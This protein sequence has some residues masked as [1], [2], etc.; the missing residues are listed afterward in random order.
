MR[1]VLVATMLTCALPA[2][3]AQTQ[4][5]AET[6]GDPKPDTL[7]AENFL[8]RQRYEDAIRQS[9]LALGRDERYVPAMVV[10]AKAYY[11]ERK[12]EL[13]TS[14]IDIAK[15]IDPNNAECYNL[16]GFIALTR[17]DRISATAAFRKAT[18]LDPRYGNAWDNL[19]AQ[20]LYGKNYDGAL[21]AA[22]KATQLLPVFSKAW[23]NLG[24]AY[25][26]KQEYPQAETA[27]KRATQLDPNYADAYFNLGILYL[28]A[29]QMPGTDLITKL[30]TS[31][32]YLNK[33]KQLA[34][35]RLKPDDPAD[36]YI[37]EARTGIEREQKRIQRMQRQQQRGEPKT[38]PAPAG[39][40]AG[41]K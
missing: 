7:A 34:S 33:Y 4:L 15:S 10:L 12:Y 25:R 37:A 31:I 41:D 29:K 13:A 6:K 26:G 3:A 17:D 18:E 11:Y 20:Y 32:N 22:Q 5:P 19:A 28:D 36:T 1:A 21:E 30:N 8:K 40:T 35:Y 2:F 38:A 24:S 23:N 9:K 27:Y 16:L 39:K 14:I